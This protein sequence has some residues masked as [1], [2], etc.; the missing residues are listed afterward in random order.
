M[1]TEK[2]NFIIGVGGTGMR[3]L[4]TFTH[5]CAMGLYDG[6]EFNVLTLDT[7]Y[8]N[9]NKSRTEELIQKYNSI[10]SHGYDD[11]GNGKANTDTF[12]SA[13][14]NLFKFVTNYSDKNNNTFKKL[15]G[16]AKDEKGSKLAD[17]FIDENIQSFNLEH[18]YRAQTHLGSYLMYHAFVDCARKLKKG[19]GSVGENEIQLQQFVKGI[20]NAEENAK[21]FVFGSIFGGTGASTIPVIP[22]ALKKFIQIESD[23]TQDLSDKVAPNTTLSLKS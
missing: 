10:K 4:E 8:E 21:I 17:L 16:I 23:K 9:G 11:G 18:G 20:T 6:M 14:I 2:K 19:D 5:M 13:K 15:T 3:C 22:K 7:D 12:F 1:S